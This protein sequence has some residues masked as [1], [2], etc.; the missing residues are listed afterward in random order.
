MYPSRLSCSTAL[1]F[2][3]LLTLTSVLLSACEQRPRPRRV[4]FVLLD[5]ARADR[6]SSYGYDRSTT[7]NIDALADRGVVFRWH[8][9]QSTATRRSLPQL[10]YSRYF[11]PPLF[12]ASR[13]VPLSSPH[14]LFRVVDSAAISLGQGLSNAGLKTAAVSAHPWLSERTTFGEQFD[15]FFDL[16]RVSDGASKQPYPDGALITNVALD[17]IRSHAKKDFFLYLHYMDTHF[18]HSFGKEA[19]EF[20][21]SPKVPRTIL[22]RFGKGGWPLDLEKPLSAVER[23]YLDAL[24]DGSLH[25]ADY[26][27][28]R[29]LEGLER[30]GILDSTIVVVTSDHGEN[31]LEVPGRADHGGKWYDAVGRI[32]LVISFPGGLEPAVYEGLT[33]SVDVAP[34]L[35]K[36]LEVPTGSA[37]SFDGLDLVSLLD[38]A[39]PQRERAFAVNGVRTSRYKLLLEQRAGSAIGQLLSEAAPIRPDSIAGEL[40]DLTSDPR[41]AHNLWSDQRKTTHRLLRAFQAVLSP[42][43]QRYERSRR[44]EPLGTSFAIA[45]THFELQPE[46]EVVLGRN[47][48]RE[49]S[50][51][52]WLWS[53]H[54]RDYELHGQAGAPPLEIS[55]PL[56]DGRY[57]LSALVYGEC[58]LRVLGHPPR[59]LDTPPESGELQLGSVA[60]EVLRSYGEIEVNGGRFQATL[61]PGPS[62]P[63]VLRYFG[64]VPLSADQEGLTEDEESRDQQLRSLGYIQ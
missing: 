44:T 1:V 56:P 9:A 20:F 42:A 58:S 23:R 41:E 16:A 4:V 17:W 62:E 2:V 51:S 37:R 29:L 18:P 49:G 47:G 24:Y 10:F 55:F 53:R 14:D 15:E 57:H 19:R 40:Y 5:A 25:Y 64:F 11:L 54:W 35:F 31:L 28:G 39:I 36:L 52:S 34:T 43:Y 21:G 8:F 22:N 33:E 6:F 59:P 3:G 48:S 13:R 63:V 12:P 30:V 46:E 50:R 38:G 60:L 61:V 27:V 32:P 45:A 7:P 26:Q